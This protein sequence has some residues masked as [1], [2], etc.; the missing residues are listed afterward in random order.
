MIYMYV[1][2][3]YIEFRDLAMHGSIMPCKNLA[4]S[5]KVDVHQQV[6]LC[7]CVWERESV[8]VCVRERE[9]VCVFVWEC[10]PERVRRDRCPIQS[11]ERGPL[12]AVPLPSATGSRRREREERICNVPLISGFR[13]KGLGKYR[14]YA[15]YRGLLRA[16]FFLSLSLL[17]DL[18]LKGLG[19]RV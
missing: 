16:F 18:G 8:C 17:L 19:C 10:V 5:G 4:R 7:V 11:C 14:T 9:S 6:A 1:N 2:T 12:W 3:V 15:T 13:V